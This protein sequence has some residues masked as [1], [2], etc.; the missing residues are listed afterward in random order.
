MKSSLIAGLAL[1][2]CAVF[3]AID[4]NFNEA[5]ELPD[6]WS[7]DGTIEQ[8]S[9]S[10]TDKVL[11]VDGTVTCDNAG[12][13]SSYSKLSLQVK[14]PEGD[15]ADD[16]DVDLMSGYSDSQFAVTTGALL[17]ESG[18]LKV[19]V[20]QNGAWTATTA[21]VTPSAWFT[22]N[23]EFDYANKKVRG[24]VVEDGVQT[25]FTPYD[26]ITQPENTSTN[27]SSLV[28][29]G[30]S[31]VDDVSIYEAVATSELPP[32][33]EGY[34][35]V[36]L[37][38]LGVSKSDLTDEVTQYGGLTVADRVATGLKPK[39][40]NTT[41]LATAIAPAADGK[42]AVTVPCAYD[43]GQDYELWINDTKADDTGWSFV[44]ENGAITGVKIEAT[45]ASGKVLKFQVKAKAPA[46][47]A[48]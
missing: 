26:F 33:L 18:K 39:D 12:T 5:T 35:K 16:P 1:L 22:I 48:N 10:D 29:V 19:M 7:G 41:F 4:Q 27:V 20:Y 9:E 30:S 43:N 34:G 8:K 38:D 32:V 40:E 28:L 6:G 23:L 15:A 24:S 2:P 36:F 45:P 44:R 31:Q 25:E 47:S 13:P 14:A 17:E 11:A 42:V 21:T 46:A 3:A 37:E